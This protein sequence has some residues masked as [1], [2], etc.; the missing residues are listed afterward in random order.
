M[1]PGKG[2]GGHRPG[3]RAGGRESRVALETPAG[4]AHCEG[5]MPDLPRDHT[6]A[7]D[8]GAAYYAEH[9]LDQDRPALWYYARLVRRLR[10]QGGRLLDFGCGTGHLLRRLSESFRAYGYDPS[11]YA[12]RVA[13]LTAP[14]AIVLEEWRQLAEESLDVVVSLHTL[15][16]IPQP[17]P[18]LRE[19]TVRLRRGGIFLFVVPNPGGWGRRLKR[20]RWFAYRDPTHCTLWSQGQWMTAARRAGL[21]PLWVRGD[22]MWDAPYVPAL[23]VSWQ[24]VLFGAPAALQFVLPVRPFLPPALGECLV[25][26]AERQSTRP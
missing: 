26:A 17:L 14:D 23:P 12:R 6:D 25:V 4:F 2:A 18:V 7:K 13:R 16:H 20:E 5:V 21:T 8:T 10:P 22:G 1:N 9:G 24:R 3:G 15:E 11:A 19:L